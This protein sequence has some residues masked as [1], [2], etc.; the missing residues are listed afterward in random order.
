MKKESIG[1]DDVYTFIYTI[2]VRAKVLLEQVQLVNKAQQSIIQRMKAMHVR[3]EHGLVFDMPQLEKIQED[4]AWYSNS[5]KTQMRRTNSS[6]DDFFGKAL[7]DFEMNVRTQYESILS[8][9]KLPERNKM[10]LFNQ[11]SELKERIEI[12][13][14]YCKKHNLLLS[15]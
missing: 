10:R 3:F 14:S 6:H 8:M 2:N 12:L 11:L 15:A 4:D 1:V 5:L 13:R 9:V 7:I